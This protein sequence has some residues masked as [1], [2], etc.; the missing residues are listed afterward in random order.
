VLKAAAIPRE[1]IDF[2]QFILYEGGK[3]NATAG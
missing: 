1:M 3:K 2:F